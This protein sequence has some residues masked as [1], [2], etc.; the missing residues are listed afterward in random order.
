MSSDLHPTPM[1]CRR[2]EVTENPRIKEGGPHQEASHTSSIVLH[3]CIA[4]NRVIIVE[5]TQHKVAK[6][7]QV[8]ATRSAKV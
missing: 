1:P 8:H 5:T 2:V 4:S 3:K 7:Y 6:G